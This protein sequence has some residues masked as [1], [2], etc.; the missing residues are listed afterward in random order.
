MRITLSAEEII[1]VEKVT[2]AQSQS[3]TWFDQRAG[4]ITASRMHRVVHTSRSSPSLSLI[5]TI[6]YPEI[7]SSKATDW[8]CTHEERAQIRFVNYQM[9]FHDSLS[10]SASGLFLNGM[11][12]FLGASPDGIVNCS[13]CGTGLLEIKCPYSHAGKTISSAVSDSNF[14]LESIDGK[15]TLKR[16]HTYYYQVQTQL[17]VC[18][19]D[20]CD[21]CVCLFKSDEAD[22]LFVERIFPDSGLWDVCLQKST[23]FFQEVILLE[24]VGKRYTSTSYRLSKP[25]SAA[26]N[27]IEPNVST[28]ISPLPDTSSTSSCGN[29]VGSKHAHQAC[30]KPGCSY[31]LMLRQCGCGHSF[32]HICT[33]DELGKMCA[34]C[35]S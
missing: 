24:L 29:S 15:V 5:K 4:R 31:V 25:F 10:V 13:C 1:Q 35:F 26:A 11:W 18:G 33:S 21:F 19:E 12:P 23:L 30:C 3:K 14:C 7:F 16:N 27:A 9:P 2:R 17:Y 34:C 8:G 6:C 32:H 28:S 22:D 20:F